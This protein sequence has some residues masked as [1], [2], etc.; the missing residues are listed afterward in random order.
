MI[1][2]ATKADIPA[3]LDIYGPY[4]L[5]TTHS[6]EYTV[7]T[8]EVFTKRFETI[9]AQLP[10]LVWE[11]EGKVLGYAYA[12][13]P[14]S[15]SAYSWDCEVSIYLAPQVQGRGIGRTLYAVLEDIVLKQ[16]YRVIY[17]LIT[18]ENTGSLAFHEKVGYKTIAVLPNCGMKFGR[19]L[20]VVWMEKRPNSVDNPKDFPVSWHS[21]VQNDEK[22]SVNL[23]TLSL[24]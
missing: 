22:F 18:S 14:F 20:G 8:L 21:I 6:F 19:W 24:S 23:G 9:T 17:S 2:M 10:W 13:L 5:N 16:G 1:R 4:V 11:E 15:R 7:P 12:S 3:I